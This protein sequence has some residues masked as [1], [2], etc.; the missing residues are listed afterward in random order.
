MQHLHADTCGEEQVTWPCRGSC[1]KLCQCVIEGA[2]DASLARP[3]YV[4]L[5][6]GVTLHQVI[7]QDFF[8]TVSR[9]PGVGKL[10]RRLLCRGGG[11][12]L[13]QRACQMAI[14]SA[15]RG[16]SWSSRCMGAGLLHLHLQKGAQKLMQA[17]R[18]RTGS[19]QH[20]AGGFNKEPL[21]DILWVQL[22]FSTPVVR[23]A[24]HAQHLHPAIGSPLLKA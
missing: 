7:P 3:Q 12:W 24:V 18:M 6:C 9:V 22:P 15:G 17:F 23:L 16:G 20:A 11:G 10:S 1:W 13:R 19:Q 8:H 21:A 2:A 14:P 5:H 4:L